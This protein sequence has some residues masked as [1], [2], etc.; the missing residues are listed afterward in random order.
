MMFNS[1][2]KGA[3]DLTLSTKNGIFNHRVAA[4]IIENNKILAQKNN[5]ENEYYLVG[6]RVK[7]GENTQNALKRELKEELN[8]TVN[9]FKPLWINEAFFIEKNKKFHEICMYYFVDISKTNFN[10]FED[11]FQTQENNRTNTYQWLDIDNLDNI[12]LYPK[13]LKDEIKNQ[14]EYLK[15]IIT[16]EY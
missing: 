10:C 2:N 11:V 8:I 1:K 12:T 13:F 4:V 6:G 3:V 7:F 16:E 5:A 14:N 9:D 15:L